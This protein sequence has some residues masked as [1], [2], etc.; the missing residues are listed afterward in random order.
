MNIKTLRT[1]DSHVDL[2]RLNGV[3]WPTV[4]PTVDGTGELVESDT[5]PVPANLVSPPPKVEPAVS[6]CLLG[7]VLG[8]PPTPVPPPN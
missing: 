2:P 4:F 7:R 8:A 1:G 3:G 6:A 5:P